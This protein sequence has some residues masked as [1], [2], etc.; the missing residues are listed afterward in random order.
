M[1]GKRFR[2]I[3]RKLGLSQSQLAKL[4]GVWPNTV[5]IWDRGEKPIPVMVELC[6]KL[7]LEKK[8]KEETDRGEK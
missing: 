1:T 2:Q 8:Q 6:L 7:L 4:L 3:R 5:A